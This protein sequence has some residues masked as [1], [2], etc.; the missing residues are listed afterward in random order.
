MGTHVRR[1]NHLYLLTQIF[2]VVLLSFFTEYKWY[3]LKFIDKLY[4]DS[5]DEVTGML[6]KPLMLYY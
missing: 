6:N 2:N 1:I 4:I 5:H 3:T